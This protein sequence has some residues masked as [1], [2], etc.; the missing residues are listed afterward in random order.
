MHKESVSQP[1]TWLGSYSSMARMAENGRCQAW[2]W[3][4]EAEK[5][6]GGK[7]MWGC[8]EP[9]SAAGEDNG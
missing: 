4:S 9:F 7:A 3:T 8:L 5:A 6:V 2:N 1:W